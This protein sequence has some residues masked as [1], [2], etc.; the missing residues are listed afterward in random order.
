[1]LLL[2]LNMLQ[3]VGGGNTHRGEHRAQAGV[4]HCTR[5]GDEARLF[6][7]LLKHG[8]GAW[9]SQLAVHGGVGGDRVSGSSRHWHHKHLICR[10]K[11]RVR[12]KGEGPVSKLLVMIVL[13]Q[14]GWACHSR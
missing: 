3:L 5:H 4:R 10:D 7:V 12:G 1:M 9:M 14:E 6:H 13:L 8:Q 2:L 11:G